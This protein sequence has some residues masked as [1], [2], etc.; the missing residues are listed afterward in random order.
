M[1]T[2][3]DR[4]MQVVDNSWTRESFDIQK[5]LMVLESTLMVWNVT[6]FGCIYRRKNKD[7]ARLKGTEQYLQ[8]NPLPIFHQKP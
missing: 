2:H 8:L 4:F 7:L 3:D 1:W 6:T 5:N